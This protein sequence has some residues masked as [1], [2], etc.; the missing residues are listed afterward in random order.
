MISAPEYCLA[1][2]LIAHLRQQGELAQAVLPEPWDRADQNQNLALSAAQYGLAVAVCPQPPAMVSEGA[3]DSGFLQA[4]V[5][6]VILT[7]PAASVMAWPEVSTAAEQQAASTTPAAAV[8]AWPEV[9]TAAEQ[10][11]A[12]T[13]P[14]AAVMAWPEVSTAAEQ[15]SALTT[16]AAAVVAWPEV[17]TAAE[18]QSALT[19]PQ[20]HEKTS[21]E[22]QAAAAGRV[23]AACLGWDFQARGIP[24]AFPRLLEVAP[25]DTSG[26][27]SFE[28]LLGSSLTLGWR[29]NYRSYYLP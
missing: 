25:L 27:A 16:P 4:R 5:A 20:V 19:T 26:L 21:A 28:N 17:S 8:M 18:Q 15:Q 12:L 1:R 9:S 2:A 22:V 24:Y 3:T 29:V 13:T 14:A 23:M 6:V 7:T 10:Q 11:S